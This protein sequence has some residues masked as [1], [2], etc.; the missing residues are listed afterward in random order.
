MRRDANR[1]P[2][3]R[4]GP[5]RGRQVLL[6]AAAAL[7]V[8]AMGSGPAAATSG[9]VPIE[10]EV[11]MPPPPTPIDATDVVVLVAETEEF[12]LPN[13][14]VGVASMVTVLEDPF[15][16]LWHIETHPAPPDVIVTPV[17]APLMTQ[18]EVGPLAPGTYK[19]IVE[20]QHV[21]DPEFPSDM[22]PDHG[23]GELEFTV[24]PEPSGAHVAA[25]GSL[26]LLALVRRWRLER[27]PGEA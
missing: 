20:W 22:D 27:A 12:V 24:V 10:V 6:R 13:P 8:L 3:R 19:V 15:E 1:N 14:S 25:L 11:S 17:L 7:A 2:V 18:T 4:R 16:I 21:D 26:A 9:P 5:P 23:M